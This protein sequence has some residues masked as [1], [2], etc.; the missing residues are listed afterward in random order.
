MS[1]GDLAM[2]SGSPAGGRRGNPVAVIREPWAAFFPLAMV[3]VL[4]RWS[5]NVALS[6]SPFRS[7]PRF[8]VTIEVSMWRKWCVVRSAFSLFPR[9]P[10][11]AGRT[12]RLVCFVACECITHGLAVVHMFR[13]GWCTRGRIYFLLTCTLILPWCRCTRDSPRSVAPVMRNGFRSRFPVMALSAGLQAPQATVWHVTSSTWQLVL[14][15]V[16]QVLFFKPIIYLLSL[17]LVSGVF[18]FNLSWDNWLKFWARLLITRPFCAHDWFKFNIFFI[19]RD[20]FCHQS[21]KERLDVS[22]H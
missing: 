16:W 5:D 8:T 9:H 18:S 15:F 17:T 19:F 12:S 10:S 11:W 6:G 1:S 20:L 7:S 2:S 13:P 14:V 3:A 21:Q 22:R 4:G